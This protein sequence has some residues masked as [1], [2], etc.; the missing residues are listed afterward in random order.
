MSSSIWTRCG[1]GSNLQ[2]LLLK[3]WRA[4]DAEA[5]VSTRKLVDSIQEQEVLEQLIDG[6]ES[7]SRPVAAGR[8]LHPLLLSPFR[9]PPLP[10]G[11]RFGRH[12]EQSLWDGSESERTAFAEVAYYRLLFLA[13]TAADLPPVLVELSSF[14][15]PIH[16][17]RGVDLTLAPF[18]AWNEALTSRADYSATQVLGSDM[19]RDGVEAFR[20]LSARDVEGGSNCGLFT[21]R[22]FAAKRPGQFRSWICVAAPTGVEIALKDHLRRRSYHF[23][24]EYFEVEGELP[25][26]AV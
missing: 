19:R 5:V 7:S 11:S 12:H 18:D 4:V 25:A 21:P 24:R 3:P 8:G 10:H 6:S 20:Y 13:G 9:Q 22:A 17:E 16:T 2:P 15:V 26:P 23:P 14:R 1:A